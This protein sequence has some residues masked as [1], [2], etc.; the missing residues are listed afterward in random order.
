MKKQISQKIFLSSFLLMF[1]C[2]KNEIENLSAQNISNQ[3][4]ISTDQS[5]N[6]LSTSNFLKGKTL[7]LDFNADELRKEYSK[8]QTQW[9]KAT[10]DEGINFV[11]IGSIKTVRYPQNNRYTKT[12]YDLGRMLFSESKLSKTGSMSCFSCHNQNMSWADG[13]EKSM[14]I[15]AMLLKRNSPSIVNSAF[16]ETLFWD[17]R[18]KSLEEQAKMV[19]L[20]VREMDSSEEL[21]KKNLSD[22]P[23]YTNL[24]KQAFGNSEINLDKISQAISTFERTI[25]TKNNSSFDKFVLGDK[26]ALN[27]SQVRGLHIFR[28][29]GRCIN[30]HSGT[31]F[32]DNKMHNIGLVLEG[33]KHEDTGKFDLTKKDADFGLFRTPSLRNVANTAPYFHNG[34]I[35]NLKGL[36]NVYNNGFPS[37]KNK[38][39]HIRPI[40]LE[41]QDREDLKAFIEALSEKV[42]VR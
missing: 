27:D 42:E 35:P 17:S 18:A 32:T 37:S 2:E 1:A 36:L 39:P 21:V 41:P 4:A 34:L 5:L 23:L 12:K 33:T 40:G 24:F 16:H 31:N 30:C 6:E 28:T 38:S 29:A 25:V 19:L 15:D 26:T 9:P 7:K 22:S 3:V 13:L 14:G 11:E 10:I 20:N 8:P